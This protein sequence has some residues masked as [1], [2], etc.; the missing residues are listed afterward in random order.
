MLPDFPQP[1]PILLHG[2]RFEVR[3]VNIPAKKPGQPP[4]TRELIVHPGAVVI[5]PILADGNI[6]LIRNKRWAVGEEL[7]E[8]PAGTLEPPE[9][10]DQ[11]AAR[12]LIEE[13][14]YRAGRLTHLTDFYSCPGFCTELLYAFLATDLTHVGQQLEETEQITVE[15]TPWDRVLEMIRSHQIRDAKTIAALLYYATFMRNAQE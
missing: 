13:T 4:Q 8:L 15:P 9:P 11:C 1:G 12:E 3:Q 14:G 6:A 5:L 10:P 7:W 2:A